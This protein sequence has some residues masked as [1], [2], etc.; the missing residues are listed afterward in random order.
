MAVAPIVL[1][2]HPADSAWRERVVDRLC[3]TQIETWRLDG[4]TPAPHQGSLLPRRLILFLVSRALLESGA[5]P[6]LQSVLCH[7]HS[8]E[9]EQEILGLEVEDCSGWPAIRL[10]G[11]AVNR[12]PLFAHPASTN[13]PEP[14]DEPP[15][16]QLAAVEARVRA[17]LGADD[18]DSGL[19]SPADNMD[20]DELF[21]QIY[22][23]HYPRLVVF[24]GRRGLDP[25]T[26][27]DLAQKSMLRAYQGID[28][29]RSPVTAQSWIL[30]IATNVWCNWVRDNRFTSKRGA[31]ESSLES[32]QESGFEVAE[33]GGLWSL[34][35]QN[36]ERIATEKEVKARIRQRIA[37]LSARQQDCLLRWLEGSSYQEVASELGVSLQTVRGSLHKAKQRLIRELGPS[38]A[39]PEHPQVGARETKP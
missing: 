20:T 36:P 3:F 31:R 1:A 38:F 2:Y 11:F 22:T 15:P 23:Q 9:H 19:P 32:A 30:R 16:D 24:F 7:R 8:D 33:S 17:L 26:S 13:Q 39:P 6:H 25:E 35:S 14:T 34:R 29:L 27:R 4:N 10:N 21:Q 28:G 18:T 5:L 37:S 12:L